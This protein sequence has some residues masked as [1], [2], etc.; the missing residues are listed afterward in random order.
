MNMRCCF[1]CEYGVR[2]ENMDYY[3]TKDGSGVNAMDTS[4]HDGCE[5]WE[6]R[7]D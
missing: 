5:D 4:P 1:E 6:E 3:C 2:G 7:E